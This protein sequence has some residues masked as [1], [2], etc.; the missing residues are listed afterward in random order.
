VGDRSRGRFATPADFPRHFCS[1][2]SGLHVHRESLGFVRRSRII[3]CRP[4]PNPRVTIRLFI[5]VR[6]DGRTSLRTKLTQMRSTSASH[7]RYDAQGP[8][9]DDIV[10]QPAQSRVWTTRSK[11]PWGLDALPPDPVSAC[12]LELDCTA[13]DIMNRCSSLLHA[14][15]PPPPMR[16]CDTRRRHAEP[17][18]GRSVVTD[19]CVLG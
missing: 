12:E 19:A 5:A 6:R 16:R 8:L 13:E 14:L 9:H 3:F 11:F 10:A 17:R 2:Y 15:L 1:P 7:P 18:R 4:A